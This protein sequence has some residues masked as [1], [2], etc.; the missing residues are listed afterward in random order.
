MKTTLNQIVFWMVSMI[1]LGEL[2]R[3]QG[4]PEMTEKPWL[5]S[6][7]TCDQDEFDFSVGVKKANQLFVGS[8]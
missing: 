2:S 8:E 7:I 1:S 5:G 4:L 6:W 3:T